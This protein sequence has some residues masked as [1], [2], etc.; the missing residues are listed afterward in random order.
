MV[1]IST[2]DILYDSRLGVKKKREAFSTG[3]SPEAPP[4]LDLDPDPDPDLCPRRD[5]S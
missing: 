4:D 5:E 3:F 2:T 1:D